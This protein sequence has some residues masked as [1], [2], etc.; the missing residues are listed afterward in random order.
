MTPNNK[1]SHSKSYGIVKPFFW[2]D[3]VVNFREWEM[4][5]MGGYVTEQCPSHIAAFLK[6]IIKLEAAIPWMMDSFIILDS[7]DH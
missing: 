2:C 4:L 7:R 6:G 3:H 5:E 1:Q